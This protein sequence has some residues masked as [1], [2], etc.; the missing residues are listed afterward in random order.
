MNYTDDFPQAAQQLID[1]GRFIDSKG[2]V[3]ATSGNFSARLN[4][5]TIAITVSGRHKGRLEAD[6]IMR[7]DADG[8]SLDGKTPSA[9][10][11]LHTQLYQRFPAVHSVLHPH[12]LNATLVSRVFKAE[13]VLENYELLKAFSGINSHESRVVVPIFAN[14][15]NIPRLAQQVADYLDRHHIHAYIID[16]HGLYTWGSSVQETLRHLEAL[17]FLF[18]CELRLH[19]VK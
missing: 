14:D 18:E 6:D 9:E 3:P 5:G 4:D 7:I 19:G 1:A 17:D 2:W 12:S 11:L 16:G 15:Q 10:T 13:I 8:Q